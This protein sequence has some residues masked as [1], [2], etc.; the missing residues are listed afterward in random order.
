MRT[1]TYIALLG[2]VGALAAC[3]ADRAP[4]AVANDD[5]APVATPDG[6]ISH[7]APRVVRDGIALRVLDTI[8]L[9]ESDS[10]YVAKPY[11][12]AV[13]PSSGRIYVS[14]SFWGRV[15]RFDRSGVP[16]RIYGARGLGP[17]EIK[18]AGPVLLLPSRVGV[19]DV[20]RSLINMYDEATGRFQRA[21]SYRGVVT[22]STATGDTAWLGALD[23]VDS[24]GV[25]MWV[26]G[27]DS[28]RHTVPVPPVYLQSQPLAGIFDGVE[29][30]PTT[31]GLLVGF[32]GLDDLYVTDTEGRVEKIVA[33]PVRHRRGA[34][35]EMIQRLDG[36][37]YPEM[38]SALSALF[39]LHRLRSGNLALVH[40]DQT[41]ADN[42]ITARMFVSLLSSDLA[43]ACVDQ[44]VPVSQDAQPAVAFAGDTL[45]VLQQ[46]VVGEGARS[47]VQRLAIDEGSCFGGR[48]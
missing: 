28:V 41:M 25:A 44:P 46:R 14:D 16:D 12:F 20:G 30:A 26:A 47:F 22:S 27:A 43:S 36:L 11:G 38:F 4:S 31:D 34:S 3:H 2:A 17:G 18:S 1:A 10:L 45:L 39:A 42:A 8:W 29:V 15:V 32:S 21:V 7:V 23:L 19:A 13:S 24:T 33:I 37:E 9:Q 48:N 40:F 35:V 5:H 6:Q